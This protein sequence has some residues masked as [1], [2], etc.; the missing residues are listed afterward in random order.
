MMGLVLLS[1]FV[2]IV[3]ALVVIVALAASTAA[4]AVVHSVQTLSLRAEQAYVYVFWLA[5]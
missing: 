1:S 2:I 5:G 4:V 3:V